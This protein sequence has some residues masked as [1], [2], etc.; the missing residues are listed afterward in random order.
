MINIFE[1]PACIYN[2]HKYY[3]SILVNKPTDAGITSKD[4]IIGFEQ[5]RFGN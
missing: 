5:V 2:S 3:Y 1:I 4:K